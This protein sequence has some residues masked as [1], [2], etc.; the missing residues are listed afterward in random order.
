M[1]TGL[2]EDSQA[3]TEDDLISVEDGSDFVRRSTRD[4]ARAHLERNDVKKLLNK[5]ITNDEDTV[6]LKIKNHLLADINNV[7]LNA[8]IDALYKNKVCQALYAQNLVKAM[9]DN[10]LEALIELCKRKK[11][12][13][14]NVGENYNVS[15]VAWTKF[16]R[17]L[18]DT[19]ITHLYVSEHTIKLS[20]K[21]EMRAN[22]RSNRKK[23]SLHSSMKNIRVIE[24]CTNMWW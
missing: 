12:W 20:L 2:V 18:L 17:S 10:E 13:C 3:H 4:A 23:H 14:L 5:I 6:V 16:S 11:I 15:T 19:N 9:G 24:R 1:S 8:I 7:V 21:N 22:I